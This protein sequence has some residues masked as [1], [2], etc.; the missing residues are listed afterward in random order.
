MR[1]GVEPTGG[2]TDRNACGRTTVLR[3]WP[4][5]MPRLRAASPWPLGTVLM[6]ERSTSQMNAEV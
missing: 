6:L 4:K 3:V 5:F 1:S 2:I